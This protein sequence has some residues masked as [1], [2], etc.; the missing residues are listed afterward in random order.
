MRT[1]ENK[2]CCGC[3]ACVQICPH[4]CIYTDKDEEGFI[5]VRINSVNCVNCGL[6]VQVCPTYENESL[7]YAK[8]TAYAAVNK[9][10]GAVRR[11][12]S[13]GLFTTFSEFVILGGGGRRMAADLM[14]I[15]ILFRIP[16]IPLNSLMN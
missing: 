1:D 14:K 2:Y 13:G 3:G 16:L 4:S 12:S 8:G 10:P 15:F 11:S 7:F 5:K 9:N 6:C